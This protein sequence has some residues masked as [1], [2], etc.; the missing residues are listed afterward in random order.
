MLIS[1]RRIPG[2]LC[3][4][5]R[6]RDWAE[7]S[8]EDISRQLNYCTHISE[9]QKLRTIASLRLLPYLSLPFYLFFCPFFLML[10]W[11]WDPGSPYEAS[12]LHVLGMRPTTQLHAQASSYVSS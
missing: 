4:G 10:Y 8:K 9:N 12:F 11:G 1:G 7:A 3:K 5:F 2:A 6:G